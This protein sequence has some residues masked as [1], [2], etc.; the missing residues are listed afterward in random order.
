VIWDPQIYQISVR[1]LKA[2]SV[3]HYGT[4]TELD[5]GQVPDYEAGKVYQV[6]WQFFYI[7]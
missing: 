7:S 2:T 3:F 5:L 4:A 6:I 1:R